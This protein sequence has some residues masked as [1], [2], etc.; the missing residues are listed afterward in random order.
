MK[1]GPWGQENGKY[2]TW[3]LRDWT[4]DHVGQTILDLSPLYSS[5]KLGCTYLLVV[6]GVLGPD[7]WLLQ[8]RKEKL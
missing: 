2:F 6:S 4:C 3:S 8:P 1:P 7:W 5:V